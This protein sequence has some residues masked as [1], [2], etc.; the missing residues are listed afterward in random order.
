MLEWLK[1]P[2]NTAVITVLDVPTMRSRLLVVKLG[3]LQ[4]MVEGDCGS[5]SA[6][7]LKALCDDI[8]S[9]CLVRECRE[10]EE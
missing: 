8:E 3:F 5:L 4:C 2:F 7:V 1:H 10:L 9:S 6:W